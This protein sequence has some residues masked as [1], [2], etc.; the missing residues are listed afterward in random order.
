ML[1][2]FLISC[3]L[4]A[5]LGLSPPS[6]RMMEKRAVPVKKPN[7]FGPMAGTLRAKSAGSM[8]STNADHDKDHDKIEQ[9]LD[10]LEAQVAE[11][12][13][14]QGGVG[15]SVL[16]TFRKKFKKIKRKMKKIK[17]KMKRN[18]K[19]FKRNIMKKFRSIVGKGKDDKK[20]DPKDDNKDDP[21]DDKKDKSKS[22]KGMNLAEKHREWAE[23]QREKARNRDGKGK[24]QKET[25]DSN[26]PADEK[27]NDAP[28]AEDQ[29]GAYKCMIDGKEDSDAPIC[30][31]QDRM[32]GMPTNYVPAKGSSLLQEGEK[33]TGSKDIWWVI[34]MVKKCEEAYPKDDWKTLATRLR[35]VVYFGKL[36]D[37]LIPGAK[38]TA[39]LE[40]KGAITAEVMAALTAGNNNVKDPKNIGIDLNHIWVGID[41][42]NNPQKWYSLVKL[43]SGLNGAAVATW[44]GDVG[45][46]LGEHY[47]KTQGEGNLDRYYEIFAGDD[48]MFANADGYGIANQKLPSGSRN[49]K[50][51]QRMEHYYKNNMGK[52]VTYMMDAA[53]IKFKG[54][55][56]KLKLKWTGK[57]RARKQITKF[58]RMWRIHQCPHGW[59]KCIKPSKKDPLHQPPFTRHK[60]NGWG[61]TYLESELEKVT[62]KFLDWLVVELRKENP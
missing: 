50:L 1:R 32:W 6:P 26:K 8:V 56:K 22:K 40:Q 45:S 60:P 19:K 13:D 62:D 12:K 7:P 9:R 37:L 3:L 25:K 54:K 38:K 31:N 21:K 44:A 16:R 41:V 33:A 4:A 58:A 29:R 42:A 5:A 34:D 35:K 49:W 20:D 23:E 43:F 39:V 24:R 28:K 46:V 36:W 11:L 59:K 48:D 10:T 15:K 57:R 51:S 14:A 61:K 30:H 18:L 55:G 47:Y 52:R 53:G 17:R 27:E 2:L